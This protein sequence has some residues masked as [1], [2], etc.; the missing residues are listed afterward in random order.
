[1]RHCVEV[2]CAY[3]SQLV[4]LHVHTVTTE[5]NVQ[6][7]TFDDLVAKDVTMFDSDANIQEIDISTIGGATIF[8]IC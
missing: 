8:S 4:G 6:T 7:H 2:A 5:Q 3:S 1:M